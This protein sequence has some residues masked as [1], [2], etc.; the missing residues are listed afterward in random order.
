MNDKLEKSYST[1]FD[2]LK[3]ADDSGDNETAHMIQDKLYRKFVRDIINNKLNDIDE[4]KLV[5]KNMNKFVVKKDI[6]RWYS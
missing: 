3:N 6:K 2:K 1:L 5:A 4:I